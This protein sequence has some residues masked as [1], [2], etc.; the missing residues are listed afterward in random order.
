MYN[1]K[2][3]V[4]MKKL[5]N[6]SKL[7]IPTLIASSLFV[8]CS[9]EISETTC[10]TQ[11]TANTSSIKTA[12][13][14]VDLG[15]PSG[16]KWANMNVG[17][18]SESDNGI[19]FVWGD[20]TGTQVLASNLTSYTDV[21]EQTS[22]SKLF[23][24]Y[25]NA[26]ES[27]G[28]IPDTTNISKLS[29]P[30]LIDLSGIGET[31]KRDAIISFVQAKFNDLVSQSYTGLLEASLTNDEFECIF[32]WDGS[33]L[34]ER[35]P[36]LKDV[37]KLDK[38][39]TFQDTL[40]YYQT[41]DD[42][43]LTTLVIDQIGS[44][45][46]KYYA[47]ALAN[48]SAEIKDKFGE[49]MRKDYTGGDIGNAPKDRLDEKKRNSLTFVP[50][51]SIISDANHDPATANWGGKWRM[52]STADFV[53][54][55]AYCDWEFTGNGY[56]VTSKAEGNKNSI[57]LPA[58]GYRYGNQWYGNGNA[59]FYATGEITGVY[60]FPSMAEQVNG[61]KGEVTGAENMPNMLIFQHGLY[62][63]LDIYNNLSSSFGISIRPVTD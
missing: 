46:A 45:E 24:L 9:E 14:A 61:S 43:L 41:F 42:A 8:A 22:V 30:K 2:T 33:K 48:N 27:I 60:H 53:E 40:D 58:A 37:M 13:Q 25:K 47:S 31:P 18:T 6:Y 54:L 34:I 28:E 55:L 20:V 36:K 59:G 7:V 21:T 12:G 52:P 26:A 62:N 23:D 1:I 19:L 32:D 16:T 63:S 50:A 38:D 51:Y 5:M 29:E 35:L 4:I 57:F 49:V 15:L 17:A 3:S 10:D 11:Y 56:K 39:P 44:T